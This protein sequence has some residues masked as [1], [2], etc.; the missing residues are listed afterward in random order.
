M[1]SS[2]ITPGEV[3][4]TVRDLS[5]T[6]SFGGSHAVRA[7]V[8]ANLE[9]GAGESLGILG[10]SGSGKSTLAAAFL[11]LLPE[12]A[13]YKS[14]SIVFRGCNILSAAERD[15]RAIRGAQ[16]AFIPQEPALTLNPV[17]S[18]GDQIAEVIR[19]H[20]PGS[21]K[22]RKIRVEALLTEVGFDRPREIYRAYAHQ[23]SGGQRQRIAIAQAMACRPALVIADEPTSK[24]DAPLQIEILDLMRALRREHGTSFVLISH[25]PAVLAGFVD[26]IVVIYAGRIVEE[27]SITDI[28][29]KPLHPYTQALVRLT[30][31]HLPGQTRRAAFSAIPGEP[32]DLSRSERGCAFAARCP[33]RM[34]VCVEE[35]PDEST[36]EANRRVRCFLY[37]L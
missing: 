31:R 30:S 23:L 8:D 32:P 18:V 21:T 9:I 37:G 24:L 14:G 1:N 13:T 28:F 19:A 33:Q 36:P 26:R 10:E 34:K 7:L 25:D 11:R 16:I 5:V 29:R 15:L 22:D 17:I 20:F 3:L 12:G 35:T 2:P 4:A 27:G 6:Y